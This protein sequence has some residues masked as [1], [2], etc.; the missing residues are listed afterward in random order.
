MLPRVLVVDDQALWRR[1]FSDALEAIG[2]RSDAVGDF[3]EATAA[4]SRDRYDLALV[5]IAL[6]RGEPYLGFQTVCHFLKRNHPT[7]RIVAVTGKKDIDAGFMFHLHECGVEEFMSKEDL[8]L[9]RLRALI[10]SLQTKRVPRR[11]SRTAPPTASPDLDLEELR[12]QIARAVVRLRIDEGTDGAWEGGTAF[13]V[14]RSVALT[15][16]HNVEAM[17]EGPQKEVTAVLGGVRAPLTFE[18]IREGTHRR[19]DIAALRL[20]RRPERTALGVLRTAW[21]P[22]GFPQHQARRFWASRE[23]AIYGFPFF[24][25]VGHSERWVV[26]MLHTGDPLEEIDLGKTYS[27][28]AL[29]TTLRLRCWADNAHELKGISGAPI[30]H[31]G[32]GRVIGVQHSYAPHAHEDVD[33]RF[34]YGTPLCRLHE[35]W[36]GF[37]KECSGEI[38]RVPSST[39]S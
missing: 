11:P 24:P 3:N 7:V 6:E 2:C 22:V 34:V 5:D 15:A 4:L 21:L 31:V 25:G 28:A 33:V 36:P 16:Y 27:G 14:S 38:L 19:H 29:G 32:L 1:A 8:S 9:E 26:G 30:W 23:I 20:K 13:M 12:R 10:A 39:L 37:L 18:L 17:V 35:A